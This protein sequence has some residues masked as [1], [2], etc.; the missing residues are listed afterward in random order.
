MST[1]MKTT[2]SHGTGTAQA[3]EGTCPFTFL[4]LFNTGLWSQCN[5]LRTAYDVMGLGR[6]MQSCYWPIL[7][8]D[9]VSDTVRNCWQKDLS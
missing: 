7:N 5:N 6:K 1:E 4:G 2:D 8:L 3:L 9:T